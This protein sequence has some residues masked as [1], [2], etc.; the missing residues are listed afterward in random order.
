MATNYPFINP[1]SVIN[2]PAQRVIDWTKVKVGKSHLELLRKI[3]ILNGENHVQAV[4]KA[5]ELY[6]EHVKE[7]RRSAQ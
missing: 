6:Y 4:A 1:R 2:Q 3:K 5:I 7:Q